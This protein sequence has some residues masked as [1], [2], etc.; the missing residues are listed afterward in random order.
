[1]PF[2]SVAHITNS[3]RILQNSSNFIPI[4]HGTKSAMCNI[5]GMPGH[6]SASLSRMIPYLPNRSVDASS[7]CMRKTTNHCCTPPAFL[8]RRAALTAVSNATCTPWL[9]CRCASFSRHAFAFSL[10]WT[11]YQSGPSS[12]PFHSHQSL[13]N[14]PRQ[15][16]AVLNGVIPAVCTIK[17][18]KLQVTALLED[19]P[20][21]AALP[22]AAQ[23]A[24][25]L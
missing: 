15:D 9:A 14:D 12:R 7:F 19:Q 1:M 20:K 24:G 23:L 17:I 21:Q 16:D 10:L 25:V 18:N 13:L 3:D 22:S 5:N 4:Y 6:L 11:S 2:A 8:S